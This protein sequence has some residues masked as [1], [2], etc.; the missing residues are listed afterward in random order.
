MLREGL[1]YYAHMR[2]LLAAACLAVA[3]SAHAGEIDMNI[4]GSGGIPQ[5]A[6]VQGKSGGGGSNASGL[7][8][9]DA[10]LVQAD[11]AGKEL[12]AVLVSAQA[13]LKSAAADAALDYNALFVKKLE[14]DC[15]GTFRPG[16]A[17]LAARTEE[18]AVRPLVARY[19]ACQSL[20]SGQ[21]AA[22]SAS[23]AYA[24]K[25]KGGGASVAHNC[26]E[27]YHLMKFFDARASGASAAGACQKAASALSTPDL[28]ASVGGEAAV[29][30]S[31]ASI[32]AGSC[33]NIAAEP[34]F[35]RDKVLCGVMMEAA[36][37]AADA[38][39]KLKQAQ[40]LL[41]SYCPDVAALGAARKGK[42]CGGSGLCAALV[43]RKPEACAP[44]FEKL[45]DG[46]CQAMVRDKT[47]RE[48]AL[49]DAA[50]KEWRAKNPHPRTAAMSAVTEK[51]KSVDSVLFALGDALDGFEPKTDPGFA[52]RV[53]RYKEIRRQVDASLKRFK[54][55]TEAPAKPKA[56]GASKAE[57]AKP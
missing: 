10:A 50:A 30:A 42:S 41:T 48:A 52:A 46:Y 47:R 23:P 49:M 39:G 11:Q 21:E 32:G 53:S 34:W 54:L 37:G 4:K 27:G 38:C 6:P 9:L 12:D 35:D 55:A 36:A 18:Q 2:N 19:L 33:A 28:L 44:L 16:D 24:E 7:K 15:R 14:T 40:P 5:G 31:C 51:R 1:L 25:G 20:S 57:A 8:S 17:P 29:K 3:F 56:E 43:T 22:C 45:R 26:L 13:T